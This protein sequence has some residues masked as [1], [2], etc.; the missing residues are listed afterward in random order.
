MGPRSLAAGGVGLRH[1][2]LAESL[3]TG[4][5]G[6]RLGEGAVEGGVAQA[7]LE[8]NAQETLRRKG[9]SQYMPL[10]GTRAPGEGI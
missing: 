7:A 9:L 8:R 6:P 5:P 1:S 10:L 2:P 4:W 3:R